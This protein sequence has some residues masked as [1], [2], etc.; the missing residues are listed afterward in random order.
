MDTAI[1][2][3]AC[4]QRARTT[5]TSRA[6]TAHD[7]HSITA[8]RVRRQFQTVAGFVWAALVHQIILYAF[9]AC[10]L[11]RH[12]GNAPVMLAS[13]AGAALFVPLTAMLLHRARLLYGGAAE[14]A[15]GVVAG[16]AGADIAHYVRA[17]RDRLVGFYRFKR[18][19]DFIGVPVSCAIVTFVTFTLFTAG[20][21]A[22]YPIAGAA[23]F[24]AWLVMSGAAVC[25]ENRKRFGGPIRH[26]DTVIGDLGRAHV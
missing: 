11:V 24:T 10:T 21:V 19:L 6:L 18:R 7:L 25:A 20:G 9:L 26:L 22:A 8:A 4:W 13:L 16:P 23:V 12:W 1:D 3:N 15:T 14:G 2:I 5:T 17:A